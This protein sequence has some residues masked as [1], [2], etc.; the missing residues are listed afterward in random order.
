MSSI[1]PIYQKL[2]PLIHKLQS[3]E[4]NTPTPVQNVIRLRID[5]Y[6]AFLHTFFVLDTKHDFLGSRVRLKPKR[7]T[8]DNLLNYYA[9]KL[10]NEYNL[11]ATDTAPTTF[12]NRM[13]QS[14]WYPK[15][16]G[17]KSP[18]TS[19][20]FEEEILN[21]NIET[22]KEIGQDLA[23][24]L[25]GSNGATKEA[26]RTNELFNCYSGAE[27]SKEEY[28]SVGRQ[29][30][31][32]LNAA[33][34]TSIGKGKTK[35][36]GHNT[37]DGSGPYRLKSKTGQLL[38]FTLTSATF[39]EA[40]KYNV[41]SFIDGA[42]SGIYN[43][44]Q[45]RISPYELGNTNI[46]FMC[47]DNQNVFLSFKINNSFENVN[48]VD[49]LI[50]RMWITRSYPDTSSASGTFLTA[51]APFYFNLTDNYKVKVID[52]IKNTPPSVLPD[53]PNAG[54]I[55]YY[56]YRSFPSS[57]SSSSSSS[58]A[59]PPAPPDMVFIS[60]KPFC[61]FG[62]SLNMFL[63]NGGYQPRIPS[64]SSSSSAQQQAIVPV[65]ILTEEHVIPPVNV[66]TTKILAKAKKKKKQKTSGPS[67]QTGF[68]VVSIHGDQPAAGLA[69]FLISAS[70]LYRNPGTTVSA[71]RFLNEFP[72]IVYSVAIPSK[73]KADIGKKFVFA[74]KFGNI[75]LTAH[76]LVGSAP[77][78]PPSG[79]RKG[80][81][82]RKK[83]GGTREMFI[84]LRRD[85]IILCNKI[86][87]QICLFKVDVSVVKLY[88]S[89]LKYLY[90]RDFK[91]IW[92]KMAAIG[93]KRRERGT[94]QK[95]FLSVFDDQSV[96]IRNLKNGVYMKPSVYYE[97]LTTIKDRAESQLD[98]YFYDA[99]YY[100]KLLN[101]LPKDNPMYFNNNR[102][103]LKNILGFRSDRL[104]QI[105]MNLGGIDS[106]AKRAYYFVNQFVSNKKKSTKCRDIQPTQPTQSRQLRQQRQRQIQ[107]QG[108]RKRDQPSTPNRPPQPPWGSG[109]TERYSTP[110][111]AAAT[112]RSPHRG[113]AIPDEADEA[114][115]GLTRLSSSIY[116]LQGDGT[117]PRGGYISYKKNKRKSRR[118]RRKKKKT[119]RKNKKKRRKK[120]KHRR[121]KK[122]KT[123]RRR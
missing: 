79:T 1:D 112:R 47:G 52:E 39:N 103:S 74:N 3:V 66:D 111:A 99:Y 100:V 95:L 51:T 10:H 30:M 54:S 80:T 34:S 109:S 71:N 106:P 107:R 65:E 96:F 97:N 31:A 49:K 92:K 123:R 114:P 122:K 69:F 75:A 7:R 23:D 83:R 33:A 81:R 63:I 32:Y 59:A 36:K 28:C 53:P 104:L 119:R 5:D 57:S 61:D 120:T 40:K 22:V 77:S 29:R 76:H 50:T 72:H 58:A 18:G 94:W 41:A 19:R 26:K 60:R 16:V 86:F 2:A 15:T 115:P 43:K 62:Q 11:L 93:R 118:K 90:D 35:V 73:P 56:A 98:V 84:D 101:S 25:P 37:T 13:L 108:E 70:A 38:S 14:K 27:N 21:F 113:V 87:S 9:R 4:V 117:P 88:N 46:K 45:K 64:S 89:Y 105:Y 68:P 102:L 20:T 110:D 67:P 82:K 44:S 91:I 48:G 24:E 12:Y 78:P 121:K 42:G 85:E 8:I 55:Y 6:F 17:S 116:S